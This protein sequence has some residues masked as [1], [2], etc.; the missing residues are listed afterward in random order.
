MPLERWGSLSL[1][2]HVDTEALIANVLLF[3]RLIVPVMTEQPDR[4]E[5]AYWVSRGWDP[6]LQSNRLNLLGDLAVRRPW[7]AKRRSLFRTRLD[8][9]IAEQG[10]ADGKQASEAEV[11]LRG[12]FYQLLSI[13]EACEYI[14]GKPLRVVEMVTM[15]T[16]RD[17]PSTPQ[18]LAGNAARRLIGSLVTAERHRFCRDYHRNLNQ[19]EDARLY[20]GALSEQEAVFRNEHNE[21]PPWPT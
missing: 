3:D 7:D 6:D 1:D 21:T 12:G 13:H 5:R 19:P 11:L 14:Q 10:D 16:N 4:N 9:L 2:D 15:N 17:H 8:E 18:G 20:E